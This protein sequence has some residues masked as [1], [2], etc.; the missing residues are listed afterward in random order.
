MFIIWRHC[1]LDTR[2][3]H[4]HQVSLLYPGRTALMAVQTGVE[5]ADLAGKS[6][7]LPDPLS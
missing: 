4:G 1:F 2:Q 3:Y 7:P 6:R 5:V